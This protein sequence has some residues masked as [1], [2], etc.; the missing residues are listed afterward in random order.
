MVSFNTETDPEPE[1]NFFGSDLE[2]G[3]HFLD[4]DLKPGTHS[5]LFFGVRLSYRHPPEP[6]SAQFAWNPEPTGTHIF[7][8]RVGS[9]R[10]PGTHGFLGSAHTDP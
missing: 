5:N 2:L 7:K 1:T 3:T 8:T 4:S 6:T 9:T 10:N